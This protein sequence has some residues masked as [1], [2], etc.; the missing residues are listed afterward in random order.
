ML[1]ENDFEKADELLIK[2]LQVWSLHALY[3]VII[4]LVVKIMSR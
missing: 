2:F 3:W 1:N 4:A